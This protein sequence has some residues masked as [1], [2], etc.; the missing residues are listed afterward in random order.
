MPDDTVHRRDREHGLEGGQGGR[1]RLI[2]WLKLV[3]WS[4]QE[5]IFRSSDRPL[6]RVNRLLQV[7]FSPGAKVSASDR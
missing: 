1:E 2:C 4:G 7:I 6:H 5:K 3:H